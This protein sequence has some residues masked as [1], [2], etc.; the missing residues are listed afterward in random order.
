MSRGN[1][2]TEVDPSETPADAVDANVLFVEGSCVL[3]VGDQTGSRVNP[4]PP[5]IGGAL[6]IYGR[7]AH[8]GG[9]CG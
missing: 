4:A 1:S 8:S 5:V 6:E 9:V 7:T 2:S 3:M